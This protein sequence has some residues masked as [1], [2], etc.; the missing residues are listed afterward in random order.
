MYGELF[1]FPTWKVLD[2]RI[3]YPASIVFLASYEFLLAPGLGTHSEV[4]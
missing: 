1:G 2:A 4:S 3:P